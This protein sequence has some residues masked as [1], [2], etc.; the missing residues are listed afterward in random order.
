MDF[1]KK[2]KDLLEDILSKKYI[3]LE[4]QIKRYKETDKKVMAKL[5]LR[6]NEIGLLMIKIMQVKPVVEKNGQK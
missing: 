5:M 6:Q 4:R 3:K 2:E 1:T